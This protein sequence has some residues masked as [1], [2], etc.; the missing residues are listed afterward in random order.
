VTPGE[1]LGLALTW[2]V[3]HRSPKPLTR[4]LLWEMSVYD[5]SGHEIRRVAGFPH[6]W[7]QLADGEVVVSWLTVPTPVE[8]A[9]GVYQVHVNRLDPQ[10]RRPVPA[11]NAD[12]EW[13]TGTVQVR[14]P[15]SLTLR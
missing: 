1:S 8:A 9:D 12:V 5:P 2:T 6:D 7:A 10:T 4:R 11:I 13:S 3:D 14:E 15:Q